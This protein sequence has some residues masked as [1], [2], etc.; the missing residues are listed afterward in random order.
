[1]A[2]SI[3][4]L[5]EKL[6]SH[7]KLKTSYI[8]LVGLSQQSDLDWIASTA[9]IYFFTAWEAGQPEFKVL[10]GL[11]APEVSALSLHKAAFSLCPHLAFYCVPSSLVCLPPFVRTSVMLDLSA[12]CD[13]T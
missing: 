7:C 6:D 12:S 11:F 2:C 13:L 10:A 8:S 5:S 3:A 1:M 9:E 4:A